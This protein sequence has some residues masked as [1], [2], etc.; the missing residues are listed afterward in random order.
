MSKK[1]K[2]I[3]LAGGSGTR[4]HPLTIALSKQLLP[5]YNKPMIYY[6]ISVLMLAGIREILLISTP[7]DLPA[8]QLLLGDGSDFGISLEYAVQENPEGLPQAFTIGEDFIGGNSVA[9]VLGDNLFFG[10][11]F[12]SKLQN[13]TKKHQGATVFGYHVADP[14]R[15]GVVEF[16]GNHNACSL[17]EKPKNPKSNYAVTGLYFYD[18]NV[19]NLVKNIEKSARGELEITD[20]NNIYLANNELRVE[21]LG[22]GFAWLDAGTHESLADATQLVRTVELRHGY[23]VAC[24]EEI[25]FTNGW[26]TRDQLISFANSYKSPE[27]AAYLLKI[28]DGY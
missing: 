1:Y 6:S 21:V 22:R 11:G 9:L 3:V 28:V 16:D 8:Y 7:R 10:E 23:K 18:N 14:E 2:G 25:G 26:L 13:A 5:I 27:Y 4:L 20:I 24:L 19:V 15:Y 17:E 12:K